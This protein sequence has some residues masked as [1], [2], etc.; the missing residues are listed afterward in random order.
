LVESGWDLKHVHR[1][2]V[3]SATYRQDSV[4][5]LDDPAHRRAMKADPDDSLLWHARR[6]RVEGEAIRDAVLALAGNLNP[7]A[8]GIS[9]KPELPS[10]LSKYAWKVD[11]DERSRNRRSIYVLAKRNLRYP[12]FDAFDLP[13]MHNSC[14][15]RLQ[16]TTAP[17]AL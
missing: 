17:Q 9:A 3:L 10:S 11:D 2:M 13:D 5:D 4:I 7:Q 6:R 1:L 14:S 16:T 15:R 12:L 8:F